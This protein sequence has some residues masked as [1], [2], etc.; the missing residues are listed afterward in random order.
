M[1]VLEKIETQM[2]GAI[3]AAIDAA[4]AAG[5]AELGPDIMTTSGDEAKGPAR[6]Y[7]VSAVHQKMFCDLCGADFRDF[8]NKIGDVKIAAFINNNYREIE[9][10]WRTMAV[11]KSDD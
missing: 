10:L 2:H 5:Q 9:D 6:Q 8:H 4:F 11:K 7:F 1:N 3:E